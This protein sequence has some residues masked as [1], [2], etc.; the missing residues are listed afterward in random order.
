MIFGVFNALKMEW[1][2]LKFLHERSKA[3]GELT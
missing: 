2:A 3:G 1:R